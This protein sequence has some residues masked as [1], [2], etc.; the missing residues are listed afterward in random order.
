MTLASRL[1]I[2]T[3]TSKTIKSVT[4]LKKFAVAAPSAVNEV[5][6][7]SIT[8][9]PVVDIKILVLLAIDVGDDGVRDGYIVCEGECEV[10]G[11]VEGDD[12]VVSVG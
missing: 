12:E 11:V 8:G 3:F 5:E 1:T 4:L 6:V 10:D 2:T 7:T 9:T